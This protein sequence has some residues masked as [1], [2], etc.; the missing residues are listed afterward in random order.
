MKRFV[1]SAA[2]PYGHAHSRATDLVPEVDLDLATFSMPERFL[3]AWTNR[4]P[5]EHHSSNLLVLVDLL[6]QV[7]HTEEW[8]W[9]KTW[10]L[11][12]P[13]LIAQACGRSDRGFVVEIGGRRN[14]DR[15]VRPGSA[16]EPKRNIATKGWAY[17]CAEDELLDLGKSATLMADWLTDASIDGDWEFRPPYAKASE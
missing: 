5:T 10:S 1:Q 12:A 15:V 17:Y 7:G 6:K 13:N 11:D 3:F 2:T 4:S 16:C 9:V 8:A 14:T